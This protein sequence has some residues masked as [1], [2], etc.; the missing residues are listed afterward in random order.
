MW[1]SGCHSPRLGQPLRTAI[2][3][4]QRASLGASLTLY[5]G[6]NCSQSTAAVLVQTAHQ[7]T[8]A[9]R[10][11]GT[12]EWWA[13]TAEGQSCFCGSCCSTVLPGA[14]TFTPPHLHP[15]SVPEFV[16]LSGSHPVLPLFLSLLPSLSPTERPGKLMASLRQQA[17]TLAPCPSHLL[18]STSFT[19]PAPFL[20]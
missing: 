11:G 5:P 13:S 10:A 2:S 1:A 14:V 3:T 4:T 8:A 17:V 18:L 15:L 7:E 6:S 9:A 16:C 19:R 20:F 12:R